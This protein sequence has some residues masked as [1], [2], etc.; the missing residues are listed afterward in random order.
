MN[1]IVERSQLSIIG[2]DS[3][4]FLRACRA[5]LSLSRDGDQGCIR[6]SSST[7]SILNVASNDSYFL[8][9]RSVY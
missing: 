4:F 2:P 6:N 5:R 1:E 9:Q 3:R 8:K 7:C